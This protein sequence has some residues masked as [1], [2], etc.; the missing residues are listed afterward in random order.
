M[1]IS[2]RITKSNC[3]PK[4]TE[5]RPLTFDS[6]SFA[7]LDPF[8]AMNEFSQGLYKYSAH[9]SRADSSENPYLR[10]N[11][12]LLGDVAAASF[13]H[14]AMTVDGLHN[15]NP[16]LQDHVMLRIV[17]KGNVPLR[18]GD[19][20]TLMVPKKLYIYH[21]N[22]ELS[23]GQEGASIGLRLPR[24]AINY[25]PPNHHRILTFEADN[26]IGCVVRSAIDSLLGQL[27]KTS[28]NQAQISGQMI[29]N[30]VRM[31]LSATEV[32][33]E[34]YTDWRA[35]R[36]RSMRDYLLENL[37]DP[38]IG[39]AQ[40]MTRFGAS[41]A[42][43]YRSFSDDG[44]VMNFV[45]DH[46]LKVIDR[47]LRHTPYSYGCV[48]RISERYGFVDQSV[49]TKSFRQHFG[50]RPSDVVGMECLKLDSHVIDVKTA[51]NDMPKLASFWSAA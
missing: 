10:L 40:L 12:W 11:A 20:E 43:I 35:A 4:K 16:E 13:E 42:T 19:D 2:E 1:P 22:N 18:S 31:L 24:H 9:A 14:S 38:N 45:R 27:E 46:R 33:E 28:R 30:L 17:K 23:P 49:F 21:P 32:D 50:Y 34:A 47:E 6:T 39:T 36:H 44:G 26:P 8:E 51:Y 25:N 7:G 29:C 5:V 3:Q 48:K 37:N 15:I 41:R